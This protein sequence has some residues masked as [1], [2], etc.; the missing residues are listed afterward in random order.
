[1]GLD[2]YRRARLLV[3]TPD[4][5]AQRAARAMAEHRAGAVLVCDGE[6]LVGIVTDRD[7]ALEIVGGD[8]GPRTTTMR[9]VMA[10]AVVT[11]DVGASVEDAV[12]LMREHVVRRL[13][14]LENGFPV[15]LVSLDDLLLD[16]EVDGSGA[17]GIVMAQIEG[18]YPPAHPANDRIEDARARVLGR[19]RARAERTW[20]R[21]CDTVLKRTPIDERHDAARAVEIVVAAMSR[22][23]SAADARLLLGQLPAR[24]A[25]DLIA[26]CVGPD[27]R[28]GP[29]IVASELRRALDLDGED[30]ARV[31]AAVFDAFD[32]C[33]AAGDVDAFGQPP[34]TRIEDRFP[35]RPYRRAV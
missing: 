22:R 16:E 34:A 4:C 9:D 31:I 20:T 7:L 2:R 33:I 28:V 23:G 5:T 11:V 8:L 25:E 27:D 35:L 32:R 19:R 29:A 21:L 26:C 13:P 24:I 17:R 3:L 15:G 10:D 12:K 6:E 18:I 30:A 14:I 1:M